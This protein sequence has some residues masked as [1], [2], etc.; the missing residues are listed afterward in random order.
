MYD[1]YSVP[2]CAVIKRTYSRKKIGE[3]GEPYGSPET[4]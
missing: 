2:F 1:S 4:A 3:T